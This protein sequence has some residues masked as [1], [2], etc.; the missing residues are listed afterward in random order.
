MRLAIR[1]AG[2]VALWLAFGAAFAQRVEGD[3]AGARGM[4]EAEVNVNGQGE[5][6][7]NTAFARAM[8]QVLG[9]LTGNRSAARASVYT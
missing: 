4:Y 6:E 5:T 8:S 3:R 2:V 1:I 7:R 9:K